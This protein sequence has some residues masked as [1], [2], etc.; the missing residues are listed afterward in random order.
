MMIKTPRSRSAQGGTSK[1]TDGGMWLMEGKSVKK[2]KQE[3][4]CVGR[5]S[6]D[7]FVL[8]AAMVQICD[9]YGNTD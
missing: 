3:T 7:G 6:C 2:L 8:L 4:V 1:M 9:N 5:A